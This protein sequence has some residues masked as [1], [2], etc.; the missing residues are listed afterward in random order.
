ME[1]TALRSTKSNTSVQV[2]FF[3]RDAR[4]ADKVWGS[5]CVHVC[6]YPRVR[7]C[8]DVWGR[9]WAVLVDTIDTCG[10]VCSVDIPFLVV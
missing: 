9:V 5:C 4:A 2:D 6:V 10:E 7:A 3:F 1:T 8:A